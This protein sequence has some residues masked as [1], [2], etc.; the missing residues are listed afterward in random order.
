MTWGESAN[1]AINL[2]CPSDR[3][4]CQYTFLSCCEEYYQELRYVYQKIP[5]CYAYKSYKELFNKDSEFFF[6]NT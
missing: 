3:K 5:E 2:H 1:T 6:F 4:P